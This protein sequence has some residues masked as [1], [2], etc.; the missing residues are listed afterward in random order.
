MTG[1]STLLGQED[2]AI[3]SGARDPAAAAAL[4][5]LPGSN[6]RADTFERT[7]QRSPLSNRIPVANPAAVG[8]DNVVV[9]YQLRPSTPFQQ[10]MYV[11]DI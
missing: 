8:L 4:L 10:A 3:S 5:A 6:G 9:L 2:S 7:M 11:L 1:K